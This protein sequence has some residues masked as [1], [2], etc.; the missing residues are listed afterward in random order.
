MHNVKSAKGS[1][2]ERKRVG[3]GLGSTGTYSGRGGKGQTARS[4]VSG[5]RRL[6]LKRTILAQPKMRGF[7]S[8]ERKPEVVNLAALAAHFDG[9]TEV[10]IAAMKA[11]C[12][13]R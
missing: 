11:A 6:G 4:G 3:R 2:S 8:L 12:V 13:V 1:R 9:K 10:T 7:T 5:L